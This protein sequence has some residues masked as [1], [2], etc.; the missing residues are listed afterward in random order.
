M[1]SATLQGSFSPVLSLFGSIFQ[2]GPWWIH[3]SCRF[4]AIQ[5]S[6]KR[7][8]H[9]EE[10]LHGRAIARILCRRSHV[11]SEVLSRLPGC[12]SFSD[13]ASVSAVAFKSSDLVY[14]AV[15]GKRKGRQMASDLNSLQSSFFLENFDG[16]WRCQPVSHRSSSFSSCSIDHQIAIRLV[17]LFWTMI[18]LF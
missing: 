9:G 7:S 3:I 2:T 17:Q 13:L 5:V 14:S 16:C 8:S 1:F 4:G 18:L 11:A 15:L 6:S 10:S 12:Q